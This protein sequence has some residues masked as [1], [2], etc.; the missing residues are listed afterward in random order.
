MYGDVL[1]LIF[2]LISTFLLGLYVC[3]EVR[4]AVLVCVGKSFR[5]PAVMMASQRGSSNQTWS[6]LYEIQTKLV[7]MMTLMFLMMVVVVIWMILMAIRDDDAE[8]SLR[9][10]LQ[11]NLELCEIQTMMG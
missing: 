4:K 10:S 11:S 6:W 1:A 7:M 3:E 5:S 9:V 8:L 2:A